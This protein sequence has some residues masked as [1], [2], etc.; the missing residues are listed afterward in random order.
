MS[1]Q[2]IVPARLEKAAKEL[3][4]NVTMLK[5]CSPESRKGAG[6]ENHN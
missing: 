3:V 1:K 6:N 5:A 2:F 4:N